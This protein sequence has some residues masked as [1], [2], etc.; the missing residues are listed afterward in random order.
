[1]AATYTLLIS[2]DDTTIKIEKTTAR[3]EIELIQYLM[4]RWLHLS[5]NL[6]F[7][8]QYLQEFA[9]DAVIRIVCGPTS[10]VQAKGTEGLGGDD[11]EGE[12]E[13]EDDGYEECY[14]GPYEDDDGENSFYKEY[15]EP[16]YDGESDEDGYDTEEEKKKKLLVEEKGGAKQGVSDALDETDDDILMD[17]YWIPSCMPRSSKT[18]IIAEIVK[19]SS[20]P[21]ARKRFFELAR[22]QYL[23]IQVIKPDGFL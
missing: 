14:E 18:K 15:Q 2:N 10:A 13:G 11:D 20:S 12:E 6:D 8:K 22:L 7:L 23:P 4:E 9:P 21:G 1:M 16:Y 17:G 19:L 3:T 5:Y